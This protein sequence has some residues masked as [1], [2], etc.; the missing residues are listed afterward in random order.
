MPFATPRHGGPSCDS[1]I[2][3]PLLRP[4][5]AGCLTVVLYA[6]QLHGQAK[7][8]ALVDSLK[9]ASWALKD[10]E[11]AAALE[12]AREATAL[13]GRIGDEKGRSRAL[14]CMAAAQ[15]NLGRSDS[16]LAELEEALRIS[17][18]I[19]F[20]PGMVSC[21]QKL[22]MLHTERGEVAEALSLLARAE[23]LA[24]AEGN[25]EE[26]ART[27]NLKGA[28]LEAAGQFQ[29]AIAPYFGS[30][31]IRKRIGSSS[32]SMSYQNLASLFLGMG[33][34]DKAAELY[35]AMIAQAR[36]ADNKAMLADGFLN[37]SALH[38]SQGSYA[39]GLHYA[40]SA[41]AAYREAGNVRR[42][43]DVR[44]NRAL[45]LNGLRRFEQARA[46]LDSALADYQAADAVAGSASVYAAAARTALGQQRADSAL[47]LCGRGLLLTE[48]NGLG[49]LHA[50]LLSIKADALRA[51]GRYAEA[52]NVL[53]DYLLLKDSLLGEK[54]TEQLAVAEMREKYD[55]A[56]RIA[57]IERL[58]MD[59]QR[60]EDMRLRRTTERN[61]LVMAAIALLLLSA[62]LYRNV[63]HRR[64]LAI[65][66]KQIHDKL[67]N[68]LLRESEVKVLNAALSGQ[69]TERKRVAKDLH[70]RLGSMLSAVK[71]QFG[72]L[73]LRID[74]MRGE[75]KVD[76]AKVHALLDEAVHEVRNISHDMINGTLAEFGLNR[77]LQSLRETIAVKGRLEVELNLYGLEHPME[78]SMEIATYHIV[79][80]LVANALKHARPTAISI[81]LTR[82]FDRLSIMVIDNGAGFDTARSTAGIGLQNV[83]SR[84]EEFGGSMHIDSSERNGTTVSIEIPLR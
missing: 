9:N 56:N 62:L 35:A 68:E 47:A 58:R 61:V 51:L 40:D 10:S 83:R 46:D 30:L 27:L 73:E 70:D 1:T 32:L 36:E 3:P 28:A 84:A 75:L 79:Q 19:G 72:A 63:R 60:G 57:Q 66:E 11:P 2:R 14:Q 23:E 48:A 12:L 4:L 53:Q 44:L 37:T 54:A 78:R 18:R 26:L 5:L 74:T 13:A 34:A 81:S 41:M 45:A 6:G 69:E 33:K 65:Q 15:R 80:E 43:P 29:E 76:Y 59:N 38:V 71:H 17:E 82:T 20:R 16:A 77:A 39:D 42:I 21:T 55:A 8:M 31:E 50:Q 64:K 49:A 52:V 25:E 22:A 67:V 7:E 24:R